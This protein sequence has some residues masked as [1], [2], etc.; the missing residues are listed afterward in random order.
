[1]TWY[2]RDLLGLSVLSRFLLPLYHQIH[3]RLFMDRSLFCR[4]NPSWLTSG[5]ESGGEGRR[6]M[7]FLLWM[8]KGPRFI[9][10]PHCDEKLTRFQVKVYSAPHLST[11]CCLVEPIAVY[12]TTELPPEYW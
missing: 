8:S 9:I 3:T 12:S 11:P 6:A 10:F 2:S 7:R 1:M 5:K 4:H